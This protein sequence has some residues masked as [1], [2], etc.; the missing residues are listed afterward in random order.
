MRRCPQF[1]LFHV[2]MCIAYS[3]N[4]MHITHYIRLISISSRTL[5]ASLI[6][7]SVCL[8]M[9]NYPRCNRQRG[10]SWLTFWTLGGSGSNIVQFVIGS[11][12]F[13]FQAIIILAVFIDL[14]WPCWVNLNKR[15]KN[16]FSKDSAIHFA[17]DKHGCPSP[18]TRCCCE[19]ITFLGQERNSLKYFLANF[20]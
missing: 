17:S 20:I 2:S 1:W 19:N 8:Q 6:G 4:P 18:A 12:W 3:E 10:T 5:I 9:L 7:L 13:L 11:T 16:I 15:N 14:F